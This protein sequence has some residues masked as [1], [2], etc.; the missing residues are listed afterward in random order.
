MAG[1]IEGQAGLFQAEL[2][3]SPCGCDLRISSRAP[4][5]GEISFSCDS[6][7]FSVQIEQG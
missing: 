2:L 5:R 7:G 3:G 1:I 4:S 6:E